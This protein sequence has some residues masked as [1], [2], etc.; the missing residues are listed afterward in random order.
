MTDADPYT[1]VEQKLTNFKKHL[2]DS[3]TRSGLKVD[4]S[5]MDAITL[6]ILVSMV[7]AELANGK[8]AQDMTDEL[9]HH[10]NLPVSA[11]SRD[12]INRT[13]RYFEYFSLIATD[14]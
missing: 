4:M 6:S 12:D 2:C 5:L 10:Y 9:L 13:S 3:V 7:K 8:S 14:S 1:I 11:F